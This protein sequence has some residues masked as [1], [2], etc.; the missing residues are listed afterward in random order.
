MNAAFDRP[1]G[2]AIPF[3]GSPTS[4]TAER[5]TPQNGGTRRWAAPAGGEMNV[6]GGV[7]WRTSA[8]Y[9]N[10]LHNGKGTSRAAF[11]NG[12]Y[13]VS[14]FGG[15]V[16]YTDQV[17]RSPGAQYWI[18]SIDEWI[19]AAHWDP[20][21]NGSGD[22]WL[23]ANSSDT[24][25]VYGPPSVLVNG[26]PTT[27]NAGWNGSIFPG[28]NPF[29]I[30]LNAYPTALS[31]WGL[32]DTAGATTEWTEEV[33]HIPGEQFFRERFHEG[34]P[35]NRAVFFDDHVN[36]TGGGIFPTFD[37]YTQGLRVAAAVPLPGTMLGFVAAALLRYRL[38]FV[39][40]R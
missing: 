21:K 33:L 5:I 7:N 22:Y 25:P 15:N 20:N 26:Q 40:R 2:D 6:V 32:V 24:L 36:T 4:W 19:K 8:I 29:D 3:L 10:W 23:W 16:T 13:D 35:W 30:P 14:T 11:M 17:T 18:P 27:A 37:G 38:A 34:S 9:C 12:A 28:Y 1:A 31:P 39:R